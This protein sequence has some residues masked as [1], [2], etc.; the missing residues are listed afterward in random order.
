MPFRFHHV[1]P[2]TIKQ[3]LIYPADN[4]SS[5]PLIHCYTPRETGIPW[6]VMITTE[7]C[8]ERIVIYIRVVLGGD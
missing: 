8:T 6:E 7:S 2:D 4:I 3:R 5:G 1:V